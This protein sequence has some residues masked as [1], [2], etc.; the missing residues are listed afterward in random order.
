MQVYWNIFIHFYLRNNR[1]GPSSFDDLQY[2]PTSKRVYTHPSSL[3]GK[4]IFYE[5]TSAK[6]RNS[7]VLLETSQVEIL[8]TVSEKKDNN[9]FVTDEAKRSRYFKVRDNSTHDTPVT[10]SKSIRR[11]SQEVQKNVFLSNLCMC[12]GYN[13]K[14]NMSCR[15]TC[16]VDEH[17]LNIDMS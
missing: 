16:L 11:Y 13:S 7:N 2:S 10:S 12:L 3:E 15:G 4:L 5:T 14:I 1:S 17:E 9:V 8:G 6:N